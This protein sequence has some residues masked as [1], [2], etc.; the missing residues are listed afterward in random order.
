M[1]KDKE[2]PQDVSF[3]EIMFTVMSA[4]QDT[5]SMFM[6]VELFAGKVEK[7]IADVNSD[8][9]ALVGIAGLRVGYVMITAD[10]QNA[11]IIA[12]KML[13]K[14]NDDELLPEEL[15]DAFGELANNI[16]GVLKSKYF[17][18]FTKVALGLPLVISGNV[19]PLSMPCVEIDESSPDSSVRVDTKGVIIPF[20]SHEEGI[21]FHVLV[22]M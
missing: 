9:L 18:N 12:R 16:G 17:S 13:M 22:Y 15:K 19:K 21:E 1:N 20:K 8:L 10:K 11:Q 14:T 6:N 5:F 4:T 7:K 3:E 2:T